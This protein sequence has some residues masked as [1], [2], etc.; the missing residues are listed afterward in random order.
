[1]PTSVGS[2]DGKPPS[3]SSYYSNNGDSNFYSNDGTGNP[4]QYRYV[5]NVTVYSKFISLFYF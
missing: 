3:L 4:V 5:F 1:M 2:T